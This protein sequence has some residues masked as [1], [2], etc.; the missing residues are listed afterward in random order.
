[1]ALSPHSYNLIDKDEGSFLA[2]PSGTQLPPDTSPFGHELRIGLITHFDQHDDP[3]TLYADNVRLA[4]GLEELGYDSIWIAVRHFHAGWAGAPSVYSVLPAFAQATSK[5]TLA[6]AVVPINADDPVRAAEDLATIDAL[7]GGRLLIGLGK[8]VP[9]DSYKVFTSW[10]EDREAVYLRDVEKLHWALAGGTVQGGTGHLWPAD[11]SLSGRILHGTST[12][13]NV[14]EAAERGDGV[15]LERFGGGDERSV[16]GRERFRQRQVETLRLYLRRYRE[17]WGQSRTPLTAI[18]RTAFPGTLEE[19]A[20]ATEHW[21]RAD[22][23]LG[24]LDGNLTQEEKFLADNFAWGTPGQLVDD[25]LADPSLYLSDEVVLGLH[26]ARL[27]VEETLA[28]AEILIQQVAPRLRS[29][30]HERRPAALAQAY[31]GSEDLLTD[32]P[33]RDPVP[34][35]V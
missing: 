26:P 12:I 33:R 7:S 30:W 22:I 2:R 5:L 34:V 9:S 23:D 17:R 11:P 14:I 6:T 1:M 16:Q 3:T 19:A 31:A 10:R 15:L 13:A 28:K 20:K 29:A 25:L 32:K 18:S 27:T 4:Q 8:G 21:N 24:R 35:S